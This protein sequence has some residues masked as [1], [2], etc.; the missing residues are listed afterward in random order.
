M[1]KVEKVEGIDIRIY[2]DLLY[3]CDPFVHLALAVIRKA[4]LLVCPVSSDTFF[5]Y[6]VHSS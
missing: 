6:L 3:L 4:V 2:K 1:D 5:G